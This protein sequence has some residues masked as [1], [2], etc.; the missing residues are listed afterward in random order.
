MKRLAQLG[1]R[2]LTAATSVFIAACYGIPYEG[3]LH[4]RVIDSGTRTGI[5]GI[6][7]GCLDEA[8][9]V[10]EDGTTDAAGLFDFAG[11]CAQ[12]AAEDADGA[13]NGAYAARTVPAVDEA[14]VEV[15]LDPAP[16]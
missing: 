8:G 1:L 2:L 15:P 3:G 6:A 13:A 11:L 14:Y 12:V 10:L 16:Q 7:V 9:A 4:V 5:G